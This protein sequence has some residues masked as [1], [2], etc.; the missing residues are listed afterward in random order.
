MTPS[1]IR[2]SQRINKSKDQKRI[3]EP[4]PDFLCHVKED[5]G[6]IVG[7]KNLEL[8]TNR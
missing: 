6:K 5:S 7:S 4:S 2:E 1:I 8:G 3:K